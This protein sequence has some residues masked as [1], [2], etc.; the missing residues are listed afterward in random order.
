[1][2]EYTLDM[3]LPTFTGSITGSASTRLHVG[4]GEHLKLT[5]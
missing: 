2:V 5:T 4:D 3:A 1:M